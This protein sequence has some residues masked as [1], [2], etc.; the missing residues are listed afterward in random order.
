VK[1]ICQKIRGEDRVSDS[2]FQTLILE[3]TDFSTGVKTTLWLNEADGFN[4]KLLW[5]AENLSRR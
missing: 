4:V 5:Q 1:G 2:V 3:E